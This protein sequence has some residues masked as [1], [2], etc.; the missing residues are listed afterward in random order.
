[1]SSHLSIGHLLSHLNIQVGMLSTH[2][3]S[4]RDLCRMIAGFGSGA[5]FSLVSGMS[6]PTANPF[7][8]AFTTGVLFAALQ[9]GFYQVQLACKLYLLLL[10]SVVAPD[11]SIC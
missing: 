6:G 8:A 10:S 2:V 4:V 3:L 9:G 1:M 7:M 11:L 5:A